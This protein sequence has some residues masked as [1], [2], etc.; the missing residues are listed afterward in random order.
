MISK[1]HNTRHGVAWPPKGQFRVI[2]VSGSEELIT[3]KPSIEKLHVAMGCDCC[4]T[5]ILDRNQMIVMLVDDNGRS[6]GKPINRKATAL[7]H[8]VC[9]PGTIDTIHG[10]VA[11]VND[12]DF[13]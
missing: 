6:D 9:R 10:D 1:H 11:I 3:D 2:R 4:D 5:V 7:Y 13:A 8:S 12:E